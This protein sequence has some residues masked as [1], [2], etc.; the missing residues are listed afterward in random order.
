[1]EMI[2][3]I[4]IIMGFFIPLNIIFAICIYAQKKGWKF[5]SA[6]ILTLFASPIVSFILIFLSKKKSPIQQIYSFKNL[7]GLILLM[8]AVYIIVFYLGTLI[9]PYM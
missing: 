9:Y 1:M 2:A 8:I 6:L 7:N 4:I 3:T 5:S